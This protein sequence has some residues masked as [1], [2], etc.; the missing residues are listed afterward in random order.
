V[1]IAPLP[2]LVRPML[3]ALGPLPTGSRWAFEFKYDGVRAV[4]YADAGGVRAL[5][6]NDNDVTSTYPELAEVG[7]LLAGRPA[8]VDGE[9]V[10]LEPG[11]RPSFARLQ[12]RMHVLDPSPAL[13]R[14]VPVRYYVFDLL[15]LDGEDTTQLP[16]RRRRELLTGLDLNGETV[17]TPA[18]FP[19]A[20]GSSVL[21]AAEIGGFEGVVAKLLDSPYRAGRRSADWTKVPLIRTQEVLIIGFEA[22][23]GRRSG[24]IGALLLGIRDENGALRYAG[25]VGTGF[26]DAM[27]HDLQALL[28]PLRRGTA[29]VPDVPRDHARRA[30]W[31]EPALVGEVAFRTWTADGRLRHASWRGLRPDRGVGAASRTPAVT[32]VAAEVTG[33]LTTADGRWR[34]EVVDRDGQ[35]SYRI[36]HADNVIDGLSLPDVQEVLS[37]AGVDLAELAPR[38]GAA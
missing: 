7:A 27:L 22:G 32:P 16:Y 11:D 13:L 24:T 12:S 3:A 31:V 28:E 17:R 20:D 30:R 38:R 37:R 21:R 1:K 6:R 10:A 8:I 19:D 34:V 14:S 36:V 35:Q 2:E 29:P 18:N 33:A 26:T 23:Q 5:T 15:H 25:Q 9:V 4:T